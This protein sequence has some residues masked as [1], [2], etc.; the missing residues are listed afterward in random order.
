MSKDMEVLYLLTTSKMV[1]QR[2]SSSMDTVHK[3]R[4]LLFCRT[5]I[6]GIF[7]LVAVM[8]YITY[9]EGLIRYGNTCR[10]CC[11]KANGHVSDI[12][13]IQSLLT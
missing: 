7:S 10:L 4:K 1:L 13:I 2:F 11:V 3:K 9:F 12:P 6:V 8:V 5:S